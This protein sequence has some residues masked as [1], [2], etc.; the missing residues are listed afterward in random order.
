MKEKKGRFNVNPP[1][2]S[3]IMNRFYFTIGFLLCQATST[4]GAIK[5][6]E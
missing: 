4:E 3:R 2:F 5:I 6:E 1:F